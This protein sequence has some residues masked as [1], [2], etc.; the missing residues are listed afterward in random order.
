MRDRDD[1]TRRLLERWRFEQ[2]V[3]DEDG[4]TIA[5]PRRGE[6]AQE[7]LCELV[8]LWEREPGRPVD[9]PQQFRKSRAVGLCA[10]LA[11]RGELPAE[12][13]PDGWDGEHARGTW[14]GAEALAAALFCVS[15]STARRLR[16]ES[17][18]QDGGLRI[19]TGR[20][21]KQ[22]PEAKGTWRDH[23]QQECGCGRPLTE[24]EADRG[25]CNECERAER[26]ELWQIFRTTDQ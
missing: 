4:K 1:E 20:E 6:L 14:E 16:R 21:R 12:D 7:L 2:D 8:R 23:R 19:G 26:L 15:E 9:V 22:E 5:N 18:T 3:L 11:Y 17:V 13:V 25:I 10:L 24:A